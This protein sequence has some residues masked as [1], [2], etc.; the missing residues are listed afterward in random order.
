MRRDELITKLQAQR[1]LLKR[2]RVK[3]LRVFGSVAR[4]E[5]TAKSDVDLIVDYEVKPG[6]LDFIALKQDLSEALGVEVDLATPESLRPEFKDDI[7]AEAIDAQA[8]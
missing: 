4:D 8:A 1:P 7:L 5:A 3:R 2:Y 6:L